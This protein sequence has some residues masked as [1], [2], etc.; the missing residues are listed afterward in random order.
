MVKIFQSI[1]RK[2]RPRAGETDAEGR[3]RFSIIIPIRQPGDKLKKSLDSLIP[4]GG[5]ELEVF[6]AEYEECPQA[7]AAMDSFPGALT[8]IAMT[9]PG[10]YEGMNEGIKLATGRIFYFMGA[11]DRLRPGVLAEIQS[12]YHWNAARLVYG[13]VFMEDLGITYDGPFDAKKLRKKNICHQAVFYSRRL[14]ERQGPYEPR[15]RLLADYAY[16]LRAFGDPETA[17]DY[18]PA[19]IADYEGAGL[20]ANGRDEAFMQDRAH[21]NERYL[22]LPKRK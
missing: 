4:Q 1:V 10:V 3:P 13:D 8:R 19:I 2:I 18:H 20:S 17:R 12:A 16:N 22:P 7:R 21:L 5:V 15:Y 6:V 11:G 9:V 14:M